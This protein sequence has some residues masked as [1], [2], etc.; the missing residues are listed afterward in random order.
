VR[1]ERRVFRYVE[2]ELYNYDSTKKELERFREEILESSPSPPEIKVQSGLG[3]PTA[4]KV[5]KILTTTYIARAEQ[6]INAIE[7]SLNMLTDLHRMLFK[8]KYQDCL[9]WQEVTIELEISERTY[10]RIRR[11]L[12]VMVAQQL[13]LINIG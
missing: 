11:E 10:F 3:D 13:G 8:L 5:E 2:Y 9:P 1:I 12:V 6:T 4:K 7:K